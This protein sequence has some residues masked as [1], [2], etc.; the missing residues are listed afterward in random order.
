VRNRRGWPDT[1]TTLT[2]LRFVEPGGV[3]IATL[4]NYACHPTASGP[5]NTE[6]SRD[7]CGVTADVVDDA[8]GGVS[9]YVNGAIGDANP[10]GDD[11][12]DTVR[13]LGE[14]VAHAAISSLE[15]AED[16][17]GRLYIRTERLDLPLNFERL[18]QR[19][20]NAVGRAGP[21]LSALSKIGGLR[22]ASS[23]L[24][25]RGRADLAQMVAA[26]AGIAERRIERRGGRTVLPTQCG[27]LR[28]GDDVEAFAAPGEV[29][30]HLAIPLRASLGA[31]H[32][33]L[34]GL[35]HDTLGYFVPEDEWMTG[36][37]NNYEESVS[38]GRASAATLSGRLL[39]MLATGA[40]GRV[41]AEPH[42]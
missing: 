20:Q 3:P 4:I 38:M 25:A 28:I 13:T 14:A 12:F 40:T 39:G 15:R 21:A 27:Y 7:W 11:G 32:R 17:S 10:A 33:M 22:A 18:S 30:T 9:V 8:I 34:F 36:R 23:A 29:L 35:T 1:D 6:V 2:A 5:A 42:A 41:P 24:H 16:V 31:R 26:L 19:V 37:N